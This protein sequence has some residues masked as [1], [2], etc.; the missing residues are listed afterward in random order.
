MC[1]CVGVWVAGLS[2]RFL[3]A[4]LCERRSS[5]A[6]DLRLTLIINSS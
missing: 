3:I 2:E 5:V 4:S 6:A 1:V